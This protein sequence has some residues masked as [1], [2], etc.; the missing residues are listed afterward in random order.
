[1]VYRKITDEKGRIQKQIQIQIRN[2]V[3]GS[4]DLAP[5]QFV[6]D[7][8]HWLVQIQI[9]LFKLFIFC[10]FRLSR[11]YHK[12]AI[13][14]L[15]YNMDYTMVAWFKLLTLNSLEKF[16]LEVSNKAGFFF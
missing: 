1:M 9:Q 5:P 11:N 4:K 3:Y 10:N 14:V 7:T 16:F 13:A 12:K 6:L 2:P 8:D 15:T